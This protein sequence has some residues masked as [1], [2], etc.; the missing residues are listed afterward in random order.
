M[1]QEK[2]DP[3]GKPLGSINTGTDCF[4]LGLIYILARQKEWMDAFWIAE[5]HAEH[6]PMI[7]LFGRFCRSL[8]NPVPISFPDLQVILSSE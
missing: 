6:V 3:I 8:G 1:Q 4:A 5:K 2:H 7:E